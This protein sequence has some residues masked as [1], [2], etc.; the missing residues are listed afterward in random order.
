M[1]NY[2]RY[3]GIADA[4]GIESFVKLDD[5]NAQQVFIFNLRAQANRHRHAVFYAISLSEK[6]AKVVNDH[7]KL[8]H[9]KEALMALKVLGRSPVF[10]EQHNALK[11]W[12][13]I[14][15]DDLDPWS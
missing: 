2:D 14:P 10:P 8:R 13:L 7:I 3:I 15:N 5:S 1:L 11:S 6:D 9:F 4:H 12:R